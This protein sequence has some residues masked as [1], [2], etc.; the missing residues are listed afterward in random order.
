LTVRLVAGHGKGRKR[1]PARD[2]WIPP[3]PEERPPGWR[4]PGDPGRSR[5]GDGRQPGIS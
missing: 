3:R 5:T 1:E 4:V 2:A